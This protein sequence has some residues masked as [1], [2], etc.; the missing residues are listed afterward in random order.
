MAPAAK[1]LQQALFVQICPVFVLIFLNI[2]GK[3]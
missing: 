3:I 1:S 2:Y